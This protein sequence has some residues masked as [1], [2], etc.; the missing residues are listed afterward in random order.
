MTDEPLTVGLVAWVIEIAQISQGQLI[1]GQPKIKSVEVTQYGTIKYKL[2]DG[3]T[4]IF[5]PDQPPEILPAAGHVAAAASASPQNYRFIGFYEPSGKLTATL[6]GFSVPAVDAQA[7]MLGS[8]LTARYRFLVSLYDGDAKIDTSAHNDVLEVGTGGTATVSSGDGYDFLHVW[9]SKNVI[10]NGGT[11]SDRIIFGAEYGSDGPLVSGAIVDLTAGTGTN[12]FGGTLSFTKV[13]EVIGT[14]LVDQLRGN[15]SDN[16]LDGNGGYDSMLGEGGDDT[17][18][19]RVGE[20]T[21]A[22]KIVAAG[23]GGEDHLGVI[24]ELASGSPTQVLDV[25]NAANNTGVFANAQISGFESYAIGD[26]TF[27]GLEPAVAAR[28]NGADIGETV[29]GGWGADTLSGNGGNDSLNGLDGADRL[30]GGSGDDTLDSSQKTNFEN[31]TAGADFLDG[32]E[33]TDLAIVWRFASTSTFTLD[34]SDP[35]ATH[36]LADGTTLVRVERVYFGA[37]EGADAITGGAASDTILGSGG[38][39]TV[40]GG[41]GDDLLDGG[42]GLDTVRGGGGNDRIESRAG[43]VDADKI[44]GGTGR[45]ALLLDRTMTSVALILDISNASVEQ[46]LGDGTT[47]VG[48]EQLVSFTAGSASD[49]FVGGGLGD[50]VFG[51][52]GDDR[53]DGRGGVDSL[54]GGVGED[55]LLGGRANDALSGGSDNDSL[56]GGAGNDVFDGGLGNDKIV[57]GGGTDLVNW[58]LATGKIKVTLSASG[59]GDFKIAGLGTDKVSSIEGV[60]A[61]GFNDTLT[62][63]AKANRFMGGVGNDKL[64]GGAGKDTLSGGAGKDKLDGGTGDDT[65][66]FNAPVIAANADKIIGFSAGHDTF[67]L[68]NAIFTELTKT[69]GL[70]AGLFK[71]LGVDGAKLDKNDRVVYNSDTGDLAY[72]RDGKGGAA[73][74]VFAHLDNKAHLSAGDFHIV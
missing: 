15:A 69:G 72:D 70:A 39:D 43:G 37:G 73:A 51:N 12:P 10:F 50:T 38:S 56:D 55:T 14:S 16:R 8:D 60:I 24:F 1:F 40:D 19:F 2:E 59:S 62:G 36:V 57:G 33:G 47:I 53:L 6:S 9:N 3:R 45:D 17:L 35:A 22:D 44:D 46:A 23:G 49:V 7:V 5:Y 21:G 71:D 41:N 30:E 74:V 18:L 31:K 48:I 26:F 28:F 64:V 27:R 66:Q 58:S 13:E 63:N 42:D 52:G 61:G 67:E 25:V 4:A 29:N 20:R 32:G 11:G 54:S 34:L 65:F 68:E